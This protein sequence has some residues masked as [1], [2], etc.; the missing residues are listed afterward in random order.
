VKALRWVLI[1][2]V[3]VAIG[4]TLFAFDL[5]RVM[6]DDMAPTLRRGDVVLACRLCGTPDRGD[7]VVFADPE[8]K[9]RLSIRRIV[10]APGDRV[11]VRHGRVLVND[12]P[13]VERPDGTLTL[14]NIDGDGGRAH[15]FEAA[16]DIIGAH[17]FRVV[18]DLEVTSRSERSPAALDDAYFLVADRR[19]LARDSR[20]YGPVPTRQIRSIVTRVLHA[21]D[22]HPGR[23]ARVP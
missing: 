1:V 6:G 3:P 12:L 23:E 14:D 10:A 17:E 2:A 20:D 22:G 11:E 13:L 16:R 19:T 18:R 21:A 5:P 7:V 9:G 8:Q 15:G 4:L